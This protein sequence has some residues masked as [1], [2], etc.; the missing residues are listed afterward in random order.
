[1]A[2][3]CRHFKGSLASRPSKHCRASRP[4]ST[5]LRPT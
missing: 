2:N 3:K 5:R 1:L 4:A